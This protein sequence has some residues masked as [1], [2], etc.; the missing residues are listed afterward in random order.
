M[1]RAETDFPYIGARDYLHGTS[2]LSGFLNLLDGEGAIQVKRIKFQRPATSNGEIVMESGSAAD[3]AR[4]ESNVSFLG[5]AGGKRWRGAFIERQRPVSRRLTLD[6]R[7]SALKAANFGGSCHIVTQGRED[8]VRALI[9]ANKRIHEAT[10]GNEPGL[11]VRFGY[12]EDW[13]APGPEDRFEGELVAKNRLT[14]ESAE[15]VM[16]VNQLSYGG[17]GKPPVTLMLCFNV[18]HATNPNQPHQGSAP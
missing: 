11:M 5:T 2:I 16:T 3:L 7:I 10:L 13:A 8:L 6:Y 18:T 9:E 14:R 1:I 4:T 15:G 12:L 17:T